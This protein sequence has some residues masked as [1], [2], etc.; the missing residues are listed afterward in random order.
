MSHTHKFDPANKGRLTDPER[1]QILNPDVVL[2]L[3]PIAV[4]QNVA[5]VGCGV[6]YFTI[7]LARRVRPGIVYAF[8]ILPEMVQA[9]SKAVD[10]AFVDNVQVALSGES[11]IPL[12]D[13]AV[14]GVLL[15]FVLHEA[16]NTVAF[17]Q[18]LRRILT[19]GGWL[20]VIEWQKKET[21][22]G[23]PLK[24]RLS[25]EE[26][27]QLASNAGFRPEPV[28]VVNDLHYLQIFR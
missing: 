11:A 15:S 1:R 13:S 4:G 21:E 10:D 6:G 16:E 22:V 18:E 7:P 12:P 20:A 24:V 8:D 27:Q 2:G 26:C 5:D 19:V 14:D 23:P 9:T 17:F 28:Q 25:P 3:L